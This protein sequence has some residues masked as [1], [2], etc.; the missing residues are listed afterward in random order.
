LLVC[1]TEQGALV[2]IRLPALAPLTEQQLS[3]EL[4]GL[5]TA[6]EAR[7]ARVRKLRPI[8]GFLDF[9][10]ELELADLEYEVVP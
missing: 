8:L 5:T 10:G 9:S 4:P 2:R 3:I 6:G 7:D 1:R